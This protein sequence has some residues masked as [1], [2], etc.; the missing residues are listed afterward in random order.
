VQMYYD[1]C[2]NCLYPT[3]GVAYDHGH[4]HSLRLV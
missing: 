2:I 3:M 1:C 4:G